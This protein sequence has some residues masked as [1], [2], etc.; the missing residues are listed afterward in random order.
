MSLA[1][2]KGTCNAGGLTVGKI[3][4]LEA[5]QSAMMDLGRLLQ[6]AF[7]GLL[8]WG[9]P[10]SEFPCKVFGGNKDPILVLMGAKELEDN[11]M[12]ENAIWRSALM[13]TSRG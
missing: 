3:V 1:G 7:V 4:E 6:A 10:L 12:R 2:R 11:D 8:R 13:L 9:A 5:G